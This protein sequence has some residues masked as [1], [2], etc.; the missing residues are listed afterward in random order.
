MSARFWVL[1]LVFFGVLALAAIPLGRYMAR[2]FAG[3]N[4]TSARVL[5]P[6]ERWIYRLAATDPAKEHDWKQYA[7]AMLAF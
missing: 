6:V 4:T 2:V 3:E 7:L 5:G 1:N